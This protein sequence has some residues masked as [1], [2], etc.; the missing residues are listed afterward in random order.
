M[1][2]H[3][4]KLGVPYALLQAYPEICEPGIVYFDSWPFGGTTA[5][6]FSPELVSQFTQDSSLPKSPLVARELTPFTGLR[7]LVTMEGQEWKFWRSVFNPGF[8]AKNLTAMVPG[9]L[10]EIQVLKERLL[11][12]AGTGEVVVMEKTVQ[13]ATVDL[14]CRA[15]L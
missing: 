4:T 15:A 9:F 11:K 6:V 12:A 3:S 5:C 13:T 7:D 8:S 14:I 10:E 2:N 1:C